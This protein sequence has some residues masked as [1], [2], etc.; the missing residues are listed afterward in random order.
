MEFEE[1][2]SGKRAE[3]EVHHFIIETRFSFLGIQKLEFGEGKI[4][5]LKK[6]Y[7]YKSKSKNQIRTT[8]ISETGLLLLL[9]KTYNKLIKM[10]REEK[11]RIFKRNA[12]SNFFCHPQSIF[13]FKRVCIQHVK[14]I[15][16]EYIINILV[17]MMTK[18]D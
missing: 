15:C 5:F 11:K 13:L 10:K 16:K 1:N 2:N 18:C 14:V 17:V 12:T 3:K 6:K 7:F 8:K 4:T 9:I